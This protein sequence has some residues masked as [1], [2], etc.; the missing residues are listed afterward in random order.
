MTIRLLYFHVNRRKSSMEKWWFN[1]MMFNRGLEYRCGL[2]KSIDSFGPIENNSVNEDEDPSILTDMD[3][4]IHSDYDYIVKILVIRISIQNLLSD[5]TFLVLDS[6]SYS[7]YIYNWN[8]IINGCIEG[9]IRSEIGIDSS[10]FDDSN[11][12]ANDSDKYND[13]D[14]DND[15]DND[16][17]SD[18]KLQKASYILE[19][20]SEND[21]ENDSESDR[22]ND[23]ES[24]SE[25]DSKMDS[26][27]DS[28]SDSEN[29]SKMDSENDSE[30]DRENDD[31]LQKASYILEPES[32]SENDS[33]SDSENDSKMDSENDSKMDSENDSKM[34]KVQN[35]SEIERRDFSHLWVA[36]DNCYGN[37]YKR[38]FKSKMNIC[39]YCGC[40]LK[41]SSS[42]RIELLIDPGTWN[43]MDEDMFSVDPIEFNSEYE[44]SENSLEDEA[45]ENWE[46]EAYENDD[47]QNSSEDEASENS[48]E[49]EASKNSSED[50]ASKNSLE[51]E[52]SENSL[53]DEPSENDD[54]QNSSEDEHEDEAYEND[55]Y[56]NSSEDEPSENSSEDEDEPSENSSEDE[57]EDEASENDDYQNR[58]DSYQDGTGL[59][60]AV[61][62]GTGQINGIPVAIGIMDFEFMGGSMGS[63][64]GE[65]ITR[66][67][68]YAT[69]QRLPLII[70]CASGGAR[71]QEGSLSLMQMAK[72]SCALYN[73]QVNQKLFYVPILTSPTTGGVTASF[74][75]LGDIILAEPDAYIAFAGKRVI[76]E[77]LHIEVPEGSQSAEFLFEKGSFDS[78]VPRHF[79]KEVL[80]ELLDFHGFFP[81]T[82][83]EK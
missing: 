37:N 75:M 36:C 82:Q 57:D 66:L 5:K 67:I 43:P 53:E 7:I 1:S 76:E 30:S 64:V 24:D 2:S 35:S 59:L 26:E 62:T 3:N 80:S 55:D 70:I 65:K 42:D 81:L 49:D 4:T 27:N 50:E 17:E 77:T 52:P 29:D 54:Y 41:M 8:N 61:Q 32:D 23:N 33:E 31:K 60:E 56:Q 25:N 21:S 79:L 68:E 20:E 15:S 38:F 69:N 71:M 16:S 78:I 48:S 51:D 46:D 12:S 47:Y 73:Y 83:T 18:D 34:D 9:Y 22:E 44:P 6:N 19:P 45:Y 40:H 28:E 11:D 74:G 39:E 58:L 72:I 14:C 63:V 13:S 10:I